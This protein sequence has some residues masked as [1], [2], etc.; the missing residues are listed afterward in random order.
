MAK[1]SYL[2]LDVIKAF[3]EKSGSTTVAG[4]FFDKIASSL[5]TGSLIQSSTATDRP[6]VVLKEGIEEVNFENVNDLYVGIDELAIKN[7][8]LSDVA[9]IGSTV[10]VRFNNETKAFFAVEISNPQARGKTMYDAIFNINSVSSAMG[11]KIS[12]GI[13]PICG[14]F[15]LKSASAPITEYVP[16]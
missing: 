7:N 5:S 10:I 3:H 11:I 12:G 4:P 8:I 1:E 13:H 14:L 16:L 9:P 6:L 15:H 2:T